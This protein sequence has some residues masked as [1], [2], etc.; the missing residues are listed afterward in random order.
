MVILQNDLIPKKEELCS[1][2]I[3]ICLNINLK[4]RVI[5][6]DNSFKEHFGAAI[7][8]LVFVG[9]FMRFRQTVDFRWVKE[10]TTKPQTTHSF[11]F[12]T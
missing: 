5:D 4:T 3:S 10:E 6:L 9:I 1:S 2:Q 12:Y 8:T 7:M 11:T